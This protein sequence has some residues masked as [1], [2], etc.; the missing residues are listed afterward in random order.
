MRPLD[1][2]NT[3]VVYK[4]GGVRLKNG[5]CDRDAVGNQQSFIDEEETVT[6]EKM[7]FM[8]S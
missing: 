8:E 3:R 1:P 2:E 7:F 5:F 4:R 6:K